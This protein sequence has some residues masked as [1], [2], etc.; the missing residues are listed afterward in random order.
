MNAQHFVL[1]DSRVRQ[2]PLEHL[3][4]AKIWPM[5]GAKIY[6]LYEVVDGEIAEIADNADD[7]P[8]I[9]VSAGICDLTHR[10]KRI[11]QGNRIDEVIL[12]PK[13]EHPDIIANTQSALEDLQR[14]IYRQGAIP[15]IATIYPMAIGDW[16]SHRLN[17]GKTY[18]LTK[19]AEYEAMQCY[20]EDMCDA[21]NSEIITLNRNNNLKTPLLHK[22]L[23][24]NRGKNRK[25][26]KR[27]NLLVDGCHP[28]PKLAIDIA[29]SLS[30]TIALNKSN[31]NLD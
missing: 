29:R 4:V 7:P 8:V 14:F 6:D 24:H 28:T 26:T 5:S 31:I 2:L 10:F 22:C 20:L 19:A 30:K 23:E 11:F 17:S 15:V 18:T 1:G 13:S 9:Y 16:N 25:A 12:L 27:Y 3:P 21:V